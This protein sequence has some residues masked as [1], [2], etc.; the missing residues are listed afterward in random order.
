M[1]LT[2]RHAA[3]KPGIVHL[4]LGA[5]F[6]AFGAPFIEDAIRAGGGDWG[7]IGVS[8]LSPGTRDALAAQDWAY[9]TV[10]L[11]PEGEETRQIEVLSDVLVAP[12]DPEAV[13]AAMAHPDTRIVSL[14]VTEKGYCHVPAS[15]GL[16]PAHPDIVH[17][18]G[19][20]H[21]VSAPGYLV[22]AQARRRDAGLPPFTVLSC[23]NLP[24][25][26][27]LTRRVVC[28][29]AR[30]ID[31]RL[32]DWIDAEG[33]FP[34]TMVDRITPATT[35]AD[36]DRL[37]AKHGI[38]DAAPVF[39]E[40]FRQWVIEDRFVGD[41][42]P[43]FAAAGVTMTGDVQPFEDMKLRMLNGAHSALAYLGYLGGHETIS[44]T[45][46][47][48]VYKRYV[49]MLWSEG[50]PSVSPPDGVD[51]QA[52]AAALQDRFANPGI[53]HRTWQIAMDG[54]QKL[55][56]RLLNTL[57][58]ALAAGRPTDAL[59]LAVAG[60]MRYVSG[61]DEAGAPI[62]V[63]DPLAEVL[64]QT[65]ASEEAPRDKALAL[66]GL[67]DVFPAELAEQLAKP[68]GDAAEQLWTKGA[69]R[70]LEELRR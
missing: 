66:L 50:I 9:T 45:M 27:A 37:A 32:A 16:N 38:H 8:L 3:P 62:D 69:R 55:P 5:F 51:L 25:N 57:A 15:G 17:D 44:D 39:H 24:E 61:T 34:A 36:I 52:Y 12:E 70:S 18:L 58:E 48:P 41:L 46:A 49:N 6:R 64:A 19:Q 33:R 21:P 20:T 68:V 47:D 13:I 14:T 11:G 43:D 7:V 31:P 1:R 35:Q 42:R 56:Q 60:W 53:Q 10:T 40:P 54:S 63:R 30:H 28:E 26:G 65:A 67:R 22:R 4:G 2:R 29:L 59:C 23:D